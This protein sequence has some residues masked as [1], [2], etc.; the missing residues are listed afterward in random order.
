MISNKL[1]R[2]LIGGNA[3]NLTARLVSGQAGCVND[4]TAT[5]KHLKEL[6]EVLHTRR[7]ELKREFGISS[8]ADQLKMRQ[9]FYRYRS[10]GKAIPP[11]VLEYMNLGQQ[12]KRLNAEYSRILKENGAAPSNSPA[13]ARAQRQKQQ[14]LSASTLTEVV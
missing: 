10:A 2:V 3:I 5:V 6:N 14:N 1:I 4:W 13:K 9:L 11:L 8:A 12:I 7:R